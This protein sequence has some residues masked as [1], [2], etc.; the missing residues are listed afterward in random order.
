MLKNIA[1]IG[2]LGLLIGVAQADLIKTGP[3][4]DPG[5]YVI[6]W[7]SAAYATLGDGRNCILFLY[8]NATSGDPNNS[9]RCFDSATGTV[10]Y[11][12][13]DTE[14]FDKKVTGDGLNDRDNHLSLSIPG[15]GLLIA[16]GTY[17]TGKEYFNGFFNYETLHWDYRNDIYSLFIP[18]EGF[19]WST[20]NPAM[21]W[22]EELNVGFVYGG[23]LN[24]SPSTFITLIHPKEDGTF[25]L[26]PLKDI[27][28]TASCMH[29]RNS[30]VAVGPWAYVVGGICQQSPNGQTSD[31]PWFRRFNL[32]SHQWEQLADLPVVRY[33]PQVTYDKAS[34][35]I[36][37]YGGNGPAAVTEGVA[38]DKMPDYWTGRNE[39]YTWN[40]HNQGPWIDRTSAADMPAVRMPVGA[41][42][43]TTNQHC[44]RGGTY[45][46]GNGNAIDGEYSSSTIWCLKI[47]SVP[48]PSPLSLMALGTAGIAVL[49]R[50][51]SQQIKDQ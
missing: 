42:D 41:Y 7:S 32:V 15:R 39:V 4:R 13:A 14:G 16:G 9:I 50:R 5:N 35:D 34:G 6:G 46:D 17:L 29:M 25:A 18:P 27:P 2:L 31:V 48:E 12:Q 37:V 8:G 28:N 36:V 43:P 11:A 30:A 10:S 26:E 40:V 38:P 44:Y 47:A 22:S 1:I 21:S 3:Y 49:R 24:G 45:F 33:L 20:F 23:Y 19:N 51:R